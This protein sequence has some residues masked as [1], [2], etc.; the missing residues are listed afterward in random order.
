MFGCDRIG[1]SNICCTA[2]DRTL[3]IIRFCGY[4][5]YP[6]LYL[7]FLNRGISRLLCHET[8]VLAGELAV[9]YTCNPL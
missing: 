6:V 5:K 4:N 3:T 7:L 9:P 2:C 8:S 1:L